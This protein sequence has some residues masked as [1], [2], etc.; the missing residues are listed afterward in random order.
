MTIY[1]LATQGRHFG[2]W[3]PRDPSLQDRQTGGCTQAPPTTWPDLLAASG[4][5][6]F[7]RRT[8]DPPLHQGAD[9]P[10]LTS[11]TRPMTMAGF[12]RSVQVAAHRQELTRDNS[13]EPPASQMSSRFVSWTRWKSLVN[14]DKQN[15]FLLR[16]GRSPLPLIL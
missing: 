7:L 8:R 13:S 1:I 9:T 12:P 10:P 3:T 2:L 5:C 14:H 11:M 16:R 4:Y 15:Q 6:H